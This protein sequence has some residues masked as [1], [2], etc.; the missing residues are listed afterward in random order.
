[1]VKDFD[2]TRA[3]DID[4]DNVDDQDKFFLFSDSDSSPAKLPYQGHNIDYDNGRIEYGTH[5]NVF[6]ADLFDTDGTKSGQDKY[7]FYLVNKYTSNLDLLKI[8]EINLV[9][10]GYI[11]R[12]YFSDGGINKYYISFI[13]E[14]SRFTE[15][16]R[17][18]NLHPLEVVWLKIKSF[19]TKSDYLIFDDSVKTF[20][21]I[22]R[23]SQYGFI[24]VRDWK[25]K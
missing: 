16:L 20:K 7:L 12:S 5:Y 15:N 3:Y 10:S 18:F 6:L 21:G 4:L 24:L 11:I 9:R 1:M 8:K 2:R 17:I 19:L 22:K 14:D 25:R 23:G 13:D